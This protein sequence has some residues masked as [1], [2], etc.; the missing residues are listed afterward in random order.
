[1]AQSKINEHSCAFYMGPLGSYRKLRKN[2]ILGS[3]AASAG[4][5]LPAI[6]K[7][8]KA[9]KLRS[10]VPIHNSLIDWVLSLSGKPKCLHFLRFQ[11]YWKFRW[12]PST[13]ILDFGTII[14][15]LG[16]IIHLFALVFSMGFLKGPEQRFIILEGSKI[17][18]TPHFLSQW[19]GFFLKLFG[20]SW[21]VQSKT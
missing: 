2:A 21:W 20:V 14:L 5:F 3:M 9:Q 8:G 4:P 10:Y 13:I 12:P 16:T 11:G 7:N 1:M 17:P 6:L 18:Q 15:E 19:V